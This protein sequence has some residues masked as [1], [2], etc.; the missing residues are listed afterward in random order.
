MIDLA[1]LK[2]LCNTTD[3]SLTGWTIPSSPPLGAAELGLYCHTWLVRLSWTKE[4]NS[5]VKPVISTEASSARMSCAQLSPHPSSPD[6]TCFLLVAQT[7]W[8]LLEW[9]INCS[10]CPKH[11]P[12]CLTLAV[13]F[14]FT[15]KSLP[16]WY[17]QIALENYCILM[18][19]AC[20]VIPDL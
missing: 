16:A 6:P 3:C 12:T 10:P 8:I 19:W 11:Q 1:M 14:L 18:P 9:Q 20:C 2:R 17:Y 5:I 15:L 4:H 13:T 7:Q